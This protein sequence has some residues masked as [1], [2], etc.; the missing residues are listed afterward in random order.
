MS[1]MIKTNLGF[2][3]ACIII[4]FTMV[5]SYFNTKKYVEDNRW[6][7]HTLEVRGQIEKLSTFYSIA[8]NNIRGFH[9]S[10]Q[11]YYVELYEEAVRNLR[12][13]I[14]QLRELVKDNV[15]QQHNLDQLQGLLDKKIET[16]KESFEIRKKRGWT[17]IQQRAR[18][19]ETKNM[20][21]AIFGAISALMNEENRM[22]EIRSNQ[23]EFQGDKAQLTNIIS[24]LLACFLI[25]VAAFLV[26]RDSQRRRKAEK[27]IDQFF[28]LSLDLL[29]ISGMDGYFKR[30]SPSYAEVLGF[31]LEELYTKPILEF[32][33]PDDIE[34]TN[35]EIARQMQ[36][37]KVMSF[38][39]RFR[40]RNGGYRTFSWMSVPVGNLMYAVARDVTRQ[41]EFEKELVETREEAQKATIA[42]SHFLANMSHEIRTPLNG[43]VGMTDILARTDL[44]EDQKKFVAVIR[45][46]SVSLLKIVNEI[47]DFSKIEAGQVFL[48]K[49]DFELGHL[50][51]EHISLIG[52]LAHNKGIKLETAID[53][54]IPRVLKGDS[55]KISQILLNFINNAIKFTNHGKIIIAADCVSLTDVHCR[56]RLE[57]RDTGIGVTLE[58]MPF[59]FKPFVQADSSTARKFGGTGLGLSICKRFVEAM[60]GEIG[61]ESVFG[62]SST[63]WIVLDLEVS[64]LKYLNEQSSQPVKA[65]LMENSRDQKE[66]RKNIRIL[67]AED[68]RMNQMII[69]NMMKILGFT[70]VLAENGREAM[71]KFLGSKFD[72]ILM[73]QHMPEMDGVE[74]SIAIRKSEEGTGNHIPIIAFTATVIQEDQKDQFSKL[75]DD[76]ILKPVSLEALEATLA[77]W[78]TKIPCRN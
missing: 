58:Q 34:K 23:A 53:P 13:T 32:I 27:E 52:V 40:C 78:E 71:T 63:F 39:N 5:S 30:L 43:V 31:S 46:S 12:T 33:H 11:G 49:V 21:K 70:T 60:G 20:D 62:Q 2:A 74:A 3:L 76:F 24:G 8:Q 51:E 56:I 17:A 41:K 15:S 69:M 72:L 73:D 19:D 68:N 50:I 9:L 54:R 55:G 36:G 29:C 22:L 65:E 1:K 61:V 4:C 26:Y 67:V 66:R 10:E 48:D 42:K 75:M 7:A 47:L 45:T 59:L 28:T 77:K 18:G 38:E 35:Q 16:W 44:D 6:M 14:Q 64:T 57:V 37:T 25:V